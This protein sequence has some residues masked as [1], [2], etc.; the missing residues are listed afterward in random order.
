MDC[1][2]AQGRVL[3]TDCASAPLTQEL[4]HSWGTQSCSV[5]PSPD[6]PHYFFSALGQ[7]GKCP[8]HK[9]TAFTSWK[10]KTLAK[11]TRLLTRLQTPPQ[12]RSNDSSGHN[13]T[14]QSR[15]VHISEPKQSMQQCISPLTSIFLK[16]ILS[17]LQHPCFCALLPTT[18]RRM[19]EEL[20]PE[21]QGI[22][23]TP[24]SSRR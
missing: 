21:R 5:T 13:H 9:V 14:L 19:G 23:G 16:I 12:D 6:A 4:H 3:G 18:N 17:F 8:W 10:F 24:E 11:P 20:R 1:A 22:A 7:L 2:P 15:R